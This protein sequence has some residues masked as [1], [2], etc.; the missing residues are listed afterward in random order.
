MAGNTL[1]SGT[2]KT[3]AAILLTSIPLAERMLLYHLAM[4]A[5]ILLP[6]RPFTDQ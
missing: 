5:L 2:W 6:V 1:R 4:T 3:I